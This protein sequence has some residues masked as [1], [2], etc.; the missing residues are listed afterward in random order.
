MSSSRPNRKA[1]RINLNQDLYGTFAEIGAG[2]E[3][4][5]HFFR[6]GGASPAPSPKRCQR[7][8]QGLF[9]DAIYGR[10]EDTGGTSAKAAGAQDARPRVPLDVRSAWTALRSTPPSSSSRSRTRWP[11]STTT[12]PKQG[13]GWFGVQASK[14]PPTRRRTTIILHARLRE[15]PMRSSS[16]P[17]RWHCLGVN[18]DLRLRLSVYKQA[19]GPAAEPC[20]ITSSAIK[21]RME[22]DTIEMNG[23]DFAGVDNR[24]LVPATGEARDDGCGHLLSGRAEPD[25]R[26]MCCTR[27][28]SWPSAEVL[29]A[30]DARSAWT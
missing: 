3:V 8:R 10:G 6:A 1:L 30:G 14:R 25:R 20:T 23:P 28:T 15:S 2:Q 4:V 9:S 24:L 13:H 26:P 27:R 29:P 19:Q 7:L 17:D 22:I 18:L 16:M 21:D 12:R 11:R 5:R